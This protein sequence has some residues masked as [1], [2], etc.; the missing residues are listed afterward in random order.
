MTSWQKHHDLML[1]L[2]GYVPSILGYHIVQMF[3]Y[4]HHGMYYVPTGTMY[5]HAQCMH[6]YL[7]S[8]VAC[9]TRVVRLSCGYICTHNLC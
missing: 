2:V 1:L 4:R 5:A 9:A 3:F 6:M 8:D 7:S